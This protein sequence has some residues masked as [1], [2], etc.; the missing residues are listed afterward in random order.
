MVTK[1]KAVVVG[2][3][4]VEFESNSFIPKFRD[5]ESE[6]ENPTGK[7]DKYQMDL[8]RKYENMTNVKEIELGMVLDGEVISIDSR[9]VVL[10]VGNKDNIIVERK[11]HEESICKQLKIDQSIRVIVTSVSDS[12]YLIKGS[13][14]ELVK[15]NIDDKMKNYFNNN[16]G[17]EA[18]VKEVIPP[19]FVLDIPIDGITVEAFMPNTL[20]DVN[21]L[22]D[23]NTLLNTTITVMLETL[24]KD[25]MVYVVSRK[26]YLESLISSKLDAIKKNPSD[27]VYTGRVTGTMKFGVFVQFDDC[28][29]G[30][31]HKANVN[32]E[33]QEKLDEI[34]PGTIIDF[35][36]KDIIK[37]NQVIL[38]QN[39]QESLWDTIDVGD[40]VDGEILS[41]K[42]F[43]ALVKLDYETNGFIK[44]SNLAK[45]SKNIEVGDK[46][47]VS[48]ITIYKSDRKLYLTLAD[49]TDVSKPKSPKNVQ[50][51]KDKFNSK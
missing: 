28:L 32:S 27:T 44:K 23:P 14:S 45:F 17:F 6:M 16:I 41:I 25:K 13:L 10:D 12:P 40:V 42:P 31:I 5:F 50:Q 36:V 37:G 19:G 15:I 22:Y 9:Q 7:F 43:G 39:L 26:K 8:F 4:S 35:Y 24:Q 29:T 20:A 38:T 21:K 51:L 46:V 48:V 33:W 47:K 2:D 49:D 34:K 11:G 3:S 30:M 1:Q 18:H